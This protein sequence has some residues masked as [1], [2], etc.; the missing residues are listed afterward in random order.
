MPIRLV[1]LEEL[2]KY[3]KKISVIDAVL[4]IRVNSQDLKSIRQMA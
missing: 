4:N 3:S 2:I 1:Y